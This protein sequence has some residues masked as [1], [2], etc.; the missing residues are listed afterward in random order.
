MGFEGL[1]A[2]GLQQQRKCQHSA[3]Q[4]NQTPKKLLLNKHIVKFQQIRNAKTSHDT[5]PY[6]G[7]R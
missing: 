6:Y 5:L 7:R 3:T 2:C 1:S 4:K